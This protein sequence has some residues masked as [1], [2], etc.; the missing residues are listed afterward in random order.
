M[1]DLTQSIGWVVSPLGTKLHHVL[2]EIWSKLELSYETFLSSI[3]M[4]V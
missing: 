4:Y 1:I 3:I 2:Y